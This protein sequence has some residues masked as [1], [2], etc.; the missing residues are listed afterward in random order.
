MEH[1]VSGLP[2]VNKLG[3]IYLVIDFSKS[4]EYRMFAII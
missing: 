4:L 3:R 2:P 1:I